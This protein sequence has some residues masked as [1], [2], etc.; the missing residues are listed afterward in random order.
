MKRG[1]ARLTD[2]QGFTIL[3]ILVVLTILGIL[4]AISVP[5]YLSFEQRA[6]ARTAQSNLRAALPSVEAYY[7]DNQNYSA[8]TTA[9][10]E[11]I[12]AGLAPGIDVVSSSSTG[13][14]LRSR[15]SGASVYRDGPGAEVTTTACS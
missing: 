5:S 1:A 7:E 9:A 12:D 14:C 11:E 4:L 13:Y 10:L 6:S 2:E 3:E 15:A 8:M